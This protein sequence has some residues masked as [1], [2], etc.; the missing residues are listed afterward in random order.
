MQTLQRKN[1]RQ[2][3]VRVALNE[4]FH[5]KLYLFKSHE[6]TTCYVGSSNL[7][8]NGLEKNG[9]LNL[10]LSDNRPA[11][12]QLNAVFDEMWSKHTLELQPVLA[13]YQN[14]KRPPRQL[15][16][17]DDS[18]LKGILESA[19]R[20]THKPGAA[21]R[22]KVAFTWITQDMSPNSVR[23]VRQK[24]NWDERGW[25]YMVFENRGYRDRLYGYGS[26][27][28]NDIQPHG[29]HSTFYDT[30]TF[31]DI[32]TKKDFKTKDGEFF[33]AYEKVEG[34][35]SRAVTAELTARLKS[36]GGIKKAGDLKREYKLTLNQ[37][38]VFRRLLGADN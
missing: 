16:T 31:Y 30:L 32:Q 17:A 4:R 38:A 25:E 8:I 24:T 27:V 11:F 10:K 1:A 26:L 14:L 15:L 7:T 21:Q 36:E 20:T 6:R 18:G 3:E 33:I 23:V 2:L 37:E 35:K 5:W 34:S 12:E 13:R 9:E 22:H 28:L 29:R 19:K